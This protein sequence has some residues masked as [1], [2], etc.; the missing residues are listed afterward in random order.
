[1]CVVNWDATSDA[2]HPAMNSLRPAAITEPPLF[3]IELNLI[4]AKPAARCEPYSVF[5]HS[6]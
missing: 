4:I 6:D 5:A 1:M 3:A 2:A